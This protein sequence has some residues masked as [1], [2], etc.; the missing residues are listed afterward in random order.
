MCMTVKIDLSKEG[1]VAYKDKGYF[2]A[3]CKGYNATMDR[4]VRG[5]SLTVKQKLR[6]KRIARKRAQ[7]ERPYAVIKN[8]FRSSHQIVTTTLRTHTKNIF[9]CF[10]YDLLQ[11]ITLQKNTP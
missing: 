1:E 3:P 7:W 8:I 10:S 2:G 5:R 4:S 9:S 11:L 6:N